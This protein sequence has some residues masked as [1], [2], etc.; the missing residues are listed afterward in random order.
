V[1]DE[2]C[3]DDDALR[4]E[5]EWLIAAAED[6]ADDHVPERFQAAARSALSDVSLEIPLPRN[7]RL[8][9]RISQ[10][11]TGI[12]YLAERVD[13]NLRQPVAFKLLHLSEADNEAVARRFSSERGILSRLSH[14]WIVRLIDGGL[15]ADGRPFLATEYVDG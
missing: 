7:Y 6:D 10:G 14:P 4:D 13:G 12:V 2:R 8:I 5:V 1:I 9:R 11:G 15:T 3:G